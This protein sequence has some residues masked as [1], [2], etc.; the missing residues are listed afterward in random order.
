M[1]G[2]RLCCEVDFAKII[3][4]TF[5]SNLS[6]IEHLLLEYSLKIIEQF[7]SRRI[8]KNDKIGNL[9]IPPSLT[10]LHSLVLIFEFNNC[11]ETQINSI[12]YRVAINIV[13]FNLISMKQ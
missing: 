12:C 10:K 3:A 4:C 6:K 13:T 8:M 2:S 5:G 11:F 7:F 9:C 1:I